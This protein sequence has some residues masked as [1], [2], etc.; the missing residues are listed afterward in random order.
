MT[1][2][3]L[4]HVELGLRVP[5]IFDEPARNPWLAL[6]EA[7][8][9]LDLESWIVNRLRHPVEEST[10][11]LQLIRDSGDAVC[12]PLL[13]V[14]HGAVF[15][16]T[17]GSLSLRPDLQLHTCEA[18]AMERTWQAALLGLPFSGASYGLVCDPDDL[19]ERELMRL[20][21]S[22]AALLR[23]QPGRQ[24]VIF[25]GGGC[26][27]EGMAKLFSETLGS[28]LTIAGKPD[29]LGGLNLDRFKAEGIVA[30]VSSQ[31]RRI[32][33]ALATAKIA[34]QGFGPLGQ[35]VSARLESLGLTLVA[36]SDSSGALYRADGLILAD[37]RSRYLREPV[38]FGYSEAD[39]I[40]RADL[41]HL[42]C[43]VLVLSSGSNEIHGQ[44]VNT[45]SAPLVIEADWN[46]VTASAKRDLAARNI[47]VIPWSI[48]TGGAL[49]GACF[50]NFA[51]HVILDPEDL[52][53]KTRARVETALS[54]VV[55]YSHDNKD[56]VNQAARQLAV[57][58]VAESLRMC[59][60]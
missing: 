33:K 8:A 59:G 54:A 1:T 6:E 32:G 2:T 29:C 37:I 13:Q 39:H 57:E 42:K 38:L 46:A 3:D 48:A 25:P 20:L 14:Q 45:I 34:I 35:M 60:P 4:R 51:A 11:Y 22:A 36:L 26:R 17:I 53:L 47:E 58:R 27:R 21:S 23:F 31:L 7:A 52:L 10:A 49:V 15:G 44:N 43:D 16:S 50:E 19:S 24:A 18:I 55:R 40:S 41:L 28:G 30:I 9:A 56:S 5:D 12:V